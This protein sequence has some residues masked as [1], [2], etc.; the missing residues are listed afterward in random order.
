[1]IAI[2]ESGLFLTV[3]PESP[4]IEAVDHGLVFVYG[5]LE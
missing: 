5:N 3:V 2:T 4:K 1:M